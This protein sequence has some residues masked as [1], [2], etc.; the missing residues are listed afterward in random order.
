MPRNQ[1]L[2]CASEVLQ[3]APRFL[4]TRRSRGGASLRKSITLGGLATPSEG[5]H[6]V[7]PEVTLRIARDRRT[8]SQWRRGQIRA[9]NQ[10][11]RSAGEVLRSAPGCSVQASCGAAPPSGSQFTLRGLAT[12]SGGGAAPRLRVRKAVAPTGGSRRQNGGG[13][14][15]PRQPGRARGIH[16]A[17]AHPEHPRRVPRRGTI[18]RSSCPASR[19][20]TACPR[21]RRRCRRARRCRTPS[22]PACR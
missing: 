3:S 2:G 10:P 21:R 17:G 15:H 9:R 1:P 16:A 13:G 8:S 12:P 14:F 18:S 7:Q 22:R 6:H 20:S 5:A 11:H 19:P 4:R